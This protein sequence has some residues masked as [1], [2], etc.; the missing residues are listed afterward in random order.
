VGRRKYIQEFVA[1]GL[2]SASENGGL[3]LRAMFEKMLKNLKIYYSVRL[4][5]ATFRRTSF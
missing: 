1:R 2:K 3:N 5:K 4:K